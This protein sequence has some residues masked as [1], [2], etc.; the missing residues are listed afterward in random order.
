MKLDAKYF[1]TNSIS[2]SMIKT[3]SLRM[4]TDLAHAKIS[5]II[6]L[7]GFVNRKHGTVSRLMPESVPDKYFKVDFL[8]NAFDAGLMTR[9]VQQA[10]PRFNDNLTIPQKGYD[11]EYVV[12]DLHSALTHLADKADAYSDWIGVLMA[13]VPLGADGEA[14]AREFSKQSS[15]FDESVFVKKWAQLQG[16][17]YPGNPATIF[18]MAQR[19][20]WKNPGLTRSPV[21]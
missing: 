10:V 9:T 6:R 11:R 4:E 17:S 1:S 5:Q 3:F 18:L 19:A 2:K 21:R 7:P 16:Q 14:L 12:Q 13:L 15:K 8:L 20:G